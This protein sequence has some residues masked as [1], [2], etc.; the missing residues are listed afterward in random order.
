MPALLFNLCSSEFTWRLTLTL[1]TRPLNFEGNQIIEEWAVVWSIQCFKVYDSHERQACARNVLELVPP[2]P[3]SGSRQTYI[4]KKSESTHKLP[5]IVF[6]LYQ[7]WFLNESRAS[8]DFQVQQ[9]A[10][11]R[12]V[13]Q[14]MH[15]NFVG[16]WREVL[17]TRSRWMHIRTALLQRA[18]PFRSNRAVLFNLWRSSSYPQESGKL[19]DGGQPGGDV[20]YIW[21]TIYLKLY[22]NLEIMYDSLYIPNSSAPWKH[23]VACWIP[24]VPK[25]PKWPWGYWL[26]L[27]WSVYFLRN[28]VIISVIG[29]SISRKAG[30][31]PASLALHQSCGIWS[32]LK[33]SY[34]TTSTSRSLYQHQR[35]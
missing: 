19:C 15:E 9:E 17:N 14:R 33:V 5:G 20:V 28:F 3:L 30:P 31:E 10:E 21:G 12:V 2:P 22:T 29:S 7:T 23:L 25:S 8:R 27:F 35:R 32:N 11:Q 26:C 6:Y 24:V 1:L 4:V 34:S 18:S 13:A 16:G